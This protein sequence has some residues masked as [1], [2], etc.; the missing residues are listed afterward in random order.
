M[1]AEDVSYSEKFN[2]CMKYSEGVTVIMRACY[3]DELDSQ[4]NRLNTNYRNY[5][6]PMS[7]DIK[8]NFVNS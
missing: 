5:I 2:E 7:A 4:D 1:F 6:S 3:S 8:K